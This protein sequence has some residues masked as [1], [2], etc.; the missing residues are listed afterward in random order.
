MIS[1]IISLVIFLLTFSVYIL[2]Q[3][4]VLGNNFVI[5]KTYLI[6]FGGLIVDSV[7]EYRYISVNNVP[8]LPVTS[9]FLYITLAL[10][11]IMVSM[12]PLLGDE[13]PSSK[14]VLF[15]RKRK[16]VPFSDIVNMFSYDNLILKRLD[17]M[18]G[19]SWIKLEKG[20]YIILPKGELIASI[21]LKYRKLI[22]LKLTG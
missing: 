5:I 9:I 11:L 4:T 18:I 16:S 6:F 13:S 15:V 17:D 12:T 10:A 19:Q 2:L 1:I 7:F 3:R 8:S 22:N 21:V 20:N 14:I